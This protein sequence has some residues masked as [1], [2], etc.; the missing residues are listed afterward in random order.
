MVRATWN[1]AGMISLQSL[2]V[3]VVEDEPLIGLDI[4]GILHAEGVTTHGA[5]T[6]ER[7]RELIAVHRPDA[8]VLDALLPDGDSFTLARELAGAG[9]GV[10]FVTG[11]ARGIPDDLSPCPV[12]EKPFT[13]ED[14]TKAVRDA[15]ER[16]V[17]ASGRSG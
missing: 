11:Y 7:A 5:E 6:L 9:I 17:P 1:R 2:S 10:V 4:E 16:R 8:A 12:V 14:L 3:L 15:L 13:P